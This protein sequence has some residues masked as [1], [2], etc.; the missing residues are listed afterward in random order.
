MWESKVLITWV[1]YGTGEEWKNWEIWED[2]YELSHWE[3]DM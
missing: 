3:A 2:I 1:R